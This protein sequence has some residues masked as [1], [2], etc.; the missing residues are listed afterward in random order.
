MNRSFLALTLSVA[1]VVMGCS[2]RGEEA[3]GTTDQALSNVPACSGGDGSS[4]APFIIGAACTYSPTAASSGA[5]AFF[6]F[7]SP[8]PA[9]AKLNIAAATAAGG[10]GV[11]T[12]AQQNADGSCGQLLGSLDK[13]P[14]L[15]TAVVP[16][17]GQCMVLGQVSGSVLIGN[18][19]SPPPS[20]GGANP[21][22]SGDVCAPLA[23]KNAALQMQVTQLTAQV[24]QLK[25]QCGS[26]APPVAPAACQAQLDAISKLVSTVQSDVTKLSAAS[27]H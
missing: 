9:G 16:I 12:T 25:S 13:A 7:E 22:P 11:V 17:K 3:L 5:P 20:D 4:K 21:P 23:D 26:A 2:A 8:I 15:P 18:P 14:Q 24:A 1:S 27:A 10:K 6:A 19:P